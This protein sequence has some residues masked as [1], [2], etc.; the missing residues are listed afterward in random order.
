[1]RSA[2]NCLGSSTSRSS[3]TSR[4]PVTITGSTRSRLR[5]ISASQVVTLGTTLEMMTPSTSASPWPS[6]ASSAA[7]MANHSS[8]I[9]SR[10]VD[11]RYAVV[12]SPDVAKS[13][14]VVFV[15]PTSTA[16]SMTILWRPAFPR[17]RDSDE[18]PAQLVLLVL[19]RHR[20]DVVARQQLGSRVGHDQVCSSGDG[21]DRGVRWQLDLG[22]GAVSDGRGLRNL[23]VDDRQ[24][25]MEAHEM[26]ER[27]LGYRLLDQVEDVVGLANGDVDPQHPKEMFI[28]WIVDA[29]NRSRN[30]KLLACNLADHEVV[31]VLAGHRDYDVGARGARRGL[32]SCLGAVS[33]HGDGAEHVVDLRDALGV[34]LDEQDLVPFSKEVLGQVVADLP[35]SGNDDVHD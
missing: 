35:A 1:M 14:N 2:P 12:S 11:S 25:L 33:G 17:A 23:G 24:I 27:A 28:L 7:S 26:D 34:A 9:R 13:P 10:S 20:D 8:G 29:G 22:D 19:V 6:E 4:S 32:R 31:L 16:R 30:A 21:G 18:Q 15:L 3:P 5:V